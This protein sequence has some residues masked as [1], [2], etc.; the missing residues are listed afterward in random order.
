MKS[1]ETKGN[2]IAFERKIPVRYQPDIFIVGG[3]PAGLAAAIAA[4]KQ[5][6]SVYLIEKQS[7]VFI[8]ACGDCNNYRDT[9]NFSVGDLQS[10]LKEFGA[11]LPNC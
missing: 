5:G 4:S 7:W 10:K 2:S 6:K 8:D 3:G 9:R 11:F 1:I